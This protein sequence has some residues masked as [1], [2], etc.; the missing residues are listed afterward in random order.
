M[1]LFG[2]AGL[3]VLLAGCA[4]AHEPHYPPGVPYAC[5]TDGEARVVYQPGTVSRAP[6]AR[7]QHRGQ[8]YVMTAEPS[9][10]GLRYVVTD[11]HMVRTWTVNGDIGELSAIA[12]DAPQDAVA[13]T[14]SCPRWPD[15][16][17]AV[18]PP[19]DEPPHH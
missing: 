8:V 10:F 5:T 2:S 15:R 6:R 19:A 11:D 9:A 7:V 1:R 13:E 14:I 3:S 4:T 18:P 17:G 16:A 12:R